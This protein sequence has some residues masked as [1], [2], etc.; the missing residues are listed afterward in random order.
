[1]PHYCGCCGAVETG[2]RWLWCYR[3]ER[4][5]LK[6]KPGGPP[7]WERTFEAQFGKPCPYSEAAA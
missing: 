1:M 6:D 4:H 3:C 5:V 2:E 7:M